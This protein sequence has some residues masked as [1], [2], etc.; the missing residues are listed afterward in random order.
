MATNLENR[1]GRYVWRFDFDAL[2]QMLRDF[3]NEDLWSVLENPPGRV[4]IH[5]VKAR[6]SSLLTPAAVQRIRD[7]SKN[8]RVFLHEVDGGHWVNADNP[9]GLLALLSQYL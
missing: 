1:D 7:L 2:E 5:M 8:G 3:F 4:Q 9:A 6:E